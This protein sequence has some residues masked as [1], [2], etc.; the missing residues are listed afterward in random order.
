MLISLNGIYKYID[1]V[2]NEEKKRKSIL[3]FCSFSGERILLE[4]F[5][6]GINNEM[7][8]H[9]III[10]VFFLLFIFQFC[11]KLLVLRQTHQIKC[12]KIFLFFSASYFIIIIFAF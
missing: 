11:L 1:F 5:F 4:D 6:S 8:F 12:N 9:L 7:Q 2:N 3:L 10:F